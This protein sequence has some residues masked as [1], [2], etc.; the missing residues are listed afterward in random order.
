MRIDSSWKDKLGEANDLDK[1]EENIFQEKQM[2]YDR[3]NSF[4]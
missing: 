3:F 2:K 1:N 4:Y